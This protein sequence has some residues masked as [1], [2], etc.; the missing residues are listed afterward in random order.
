[1]IKVIN[2]YNQKEGV[3]T[4]VAETSFQID[5]ADGTSEMVSSLDYFLT[6]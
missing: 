1:M 3:A 6:M 4:C 5:Y 2:P